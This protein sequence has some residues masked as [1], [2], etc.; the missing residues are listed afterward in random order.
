MVIREDRIGLIQCIN[1]YLD[2]KIKAFEFD[3]KLV[4]FIHSKDS[5]ISCIASNMWYYYDDLED[6]FICADKDTWDYFQ[7]L[8][9]ILSSG[10]EIEAKTKIE[11]RE[12]YR[13]TNILATLSLA[14][15]G[16]LFFTRNEFKFLWHIIMWFISH[17]ILLE[18]SSDSGTGEISQ[19]R[20]DCYPFGN[21]A[22]IRKAVRQAGDFKK[23]LYPRKIEGRRIRDKN[24]ESLMQSTSSLGLIFISPLYLLLT[25]FSRLRSTSIAL[26]PDA[27]AAGN[28]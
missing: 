17:F 9:L 14:V 26:L 23:K 18:Q 19:Q 28:I 15:H 11:Y 25:V 21:I 4:D 16:Y 10:M 20:P 24:S 7:R 12:L 6:H 1:E 3:D 5:T 13:P 27:S 22:Q 2:E 8:I